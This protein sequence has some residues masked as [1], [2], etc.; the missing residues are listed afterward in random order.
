MNRDNARLY[1][2]LLEALAN[3]KTLQ[4]RPKG[5]DI[6]HAPYSHEEWIDLTRPEVEFFYPPDRYRIKPNP[7][8]LYAVVRPD[9]TFFH[10]YELRASAA[11]AAKNLNRN[12]RGSEKHR[13]ITFVEEIE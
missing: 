5:E 12:I 8:K 9:G 3:G 1:I 11:S 6:A 2:P 7:M 10:A 13:V 4:F